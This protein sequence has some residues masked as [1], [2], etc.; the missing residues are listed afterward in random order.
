[1]ASVARLQPTWQ[2]DTLGGPPDWLMGVANVLADANGPGIAKL[3]SGSVWAAAA[4]TQARSLTPAAGS[5]LVV[6]AAQSSTSGS[7]AVA[8][9]VDGSYTADPN[10]PATGADSLAAFRVQFFVL[11]VTTAGVRTI[12]LT[13]TN[14]RGFVVW[15]LTGVDPT[16]QLEESS[17]ANAINTEWVSGPSVTSGVGDYAFAGVICSTHPTVVQ[18][19]FAQDEHA[20]FGNN[21][22]DSAPS[23]AAHYAA[24][25]DYDRST[26]PFAPAEEHIWIG[27]GRPGRLGSLGLMRGTGPHPYGGFERN[28]YTRL[29]PVYQAGGTTFP[30][31]ID[32]TV[33][34]TAS[35][36]LTVGKAVTATATSTASMVRQVGKPV[37]ATVTTTASVVKLAGKVLTATVTTTAVL[38][39]MKVILKALTATVTT[40]ASIVRQV[41]KPL[42]ATVTAT[43]SIVKRAGKLVTATVTSSATIAA[44]K[45]ILRTLT[46]TV[47]LS[48]SVVNRVGKS[49]TATATSSASVVKQVGKRF[50]A[51]A[52]VT[53]SVAALRV[54]LRTLTATVTTTA[55]MT[56]RVGKSLVATVTTTA[57]VA[58]AITKSLV[59]GVSSVASMVTQAVGA[60]VGPFAASLAITDAGQQA[61]AVVNL[62]GADV[63]A[64]NAAGAEAAV[65]SAAGA[66]AAVQNVAG[67]DVTVAETIP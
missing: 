63:V 38:T 45:V 42:S 27:R 49:L 53:A 26:F 65:T 24:V 55:S 9:S 67:A 12:T 10:G 41:G 33:T 47:T 1:M 4:G 22:G 51:N 16:T 11:P 18:G 44:I 23:P 60:A 30:Q 36:T 21:D 29:H 7:M 62:A 2:G 6:F 8:D 39:A 54:F 64:Q 13:A 19:G 37:T 14:A 50:T 34:S 48:A 40:T 57:T 66:E 58:K 46:A 52:T 32:A 5:T 15:E 61:V 3:Q 56:R 25:T 31:S 35:F 59:A 43:A 17:Y 28:L 20:N